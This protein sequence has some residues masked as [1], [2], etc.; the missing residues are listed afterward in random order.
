[1]AIR[2]QTYEQIEDITMKEKEEK[3]ERVRIIEMTEEQKIEEEGREETWSY[4]RKMSEARREKER[5]KLEMMRC[6]ECNKRGHRCY[7][8]PER[9]RKRQ[10]KLV[11]QKKWRE[12]KE[13]EELS[14][15]RR[16][17]STDRVLYVHVDI[18]GRNLECLIDSGTSI[19]LMPVRFIDKTRIR[20]TSK[21]LY[22]ANGAKME[23]LGESDVIMK[24][25]DLQISARFVI[26]E[27]ISEII[28]G[29]EWLTGNDC[30]VNFSKKEVDIK[31]HKIPLE[32]RRQ[33]HCHR[34][35]ASEDIEIPARVEANIGGRIVYAYIPK[36]KGCWMAESRFEQ[37]IGMQVANTLITE[38][39]GVIPIRV[40]NV[41]NEPV[42]IRKG[43]T[44][45]NIYEVNE[46]KKVKEEKVEN[47]KSEERIE[48]LIKN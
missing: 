13:Q 7:E 34:I 27:R 18:E 48:E 44:I 31:G 33:I 37:G 26:S 42:Q 21:K 6:Y 20:P 3:A 40:I 45:C 46:I 16:S 17:W 39:P 35:I 28:L 25:G 30:T 4:R 9:E 8:C 43:R 12:S 29:V 2:L 15:E 5:R 1:M 11:K 14:K 38:D 24:V 23:L 32:N 47:V 36:E 19:N 10:G 22:A 41:N